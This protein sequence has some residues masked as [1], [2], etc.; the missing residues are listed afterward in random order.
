MAKQ[1]PA[2]W[3]RRFAFMQWPCH[4]EAQW[5]HIRAQAAATAG[6][7][8]PIQASDQNADYCRQLAG[9]ITANH[10]EDT[11]TVA[12]RDFFDLQGNDLPASAGLVVLNPPYGRRLKPDNP[13]HVFY[14]RIGRH[15]QTVFPGWRLALL[16]PH[17][18]LA[19]LLPF[20]VDSFDLSHGGLAL[21]LLYG[22]IS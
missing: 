11:V 14:T 6:S 1:I 8:A 22:I 3:H 15:L 20:P 2:G 5:Q 9:C 18:D 13:T 12:C 10:L 16:A 21:S 4:K 19:A 17:P 7:P